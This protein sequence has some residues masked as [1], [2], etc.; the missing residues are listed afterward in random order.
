MEKCNLFRWN[1]FDSMACFMPILLLC[2]S[3]S[4]FTFGYVWFVSRMKAKRT[5]IESFIYWMVCCI[6][7]W[8]THSLEHLYTCLLEWFEHIYC[9]HW[10]TP[11]LRPNMTRRTNTNLTTE[12]DWE[13]HVPFENWEKNPYFCT[14]ALITA[15]QNKKLSTAIAFA[16]NVFSLILEPNLGVSPPI[17]Q[18][19][20]SGR[21]ART[22]HSNAYLHKPYWTANFICIYYLCRVHNVNYGYMV[23]I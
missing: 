23:F 16:R 20:I 3:S 19:R 15:N 8:H 18:Q 9:P 22:N 1:I 5:Y 13:R 2:C 21:S 12:I 17:V 11:A 14:V 6:Q 7:V 10:K 4:E